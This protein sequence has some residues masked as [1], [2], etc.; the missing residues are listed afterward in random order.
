MQIWLQYILLN[1]PIPFHQPNPDDLI[2]WPVRVEARDIDPS[3]AKDTLRWRT[4]YEWQVDKLLVTTRYYSYSRYNDTLILYE[5]VTRRTV[6][7]VSDGPSGDTALVTRAR[8]GVQETGSQSWRNFISPYFGRISTRLEHLNGNPS[9]Y[10][11]SRY[12]F[13][14]ERPKSVYEDEVL[15]SSHTN[16]LITDSKRSFRYDSSG[17]VTQ[18]ITKNSST[19]KPKDPTAEFYAVETFTYF[20]KDSIRTER[21]D[22]S[23]NQ[24]RLG[25]RTSYAFAGNRLRTKKIVQ[26][27]DLARGSSKWTKVEYMYADETPVRIPAPGSSQGRTGGSESYRHYGLGEPGGPWVLGRLLHR[28]KARSI[29]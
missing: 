5:E 22:S 18:A 26:G 21:I 2:E 10:S 27:Y 7:F 11:S 23:S 8:N 17:R 1:L 19:G 3:A 16:Y 28:T 9:A 25:F 14:S 15:D 4:D 20:G 6:G 13:A 29:P 24:K 12:F